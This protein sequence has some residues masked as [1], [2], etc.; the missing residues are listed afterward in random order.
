ME[1]S[2]NRGTPKSSISMAFSIINQPFG[3][4][5]LMETHILPSVE[6]VALWRGTSCPRS[7]L[8]SQGYRPF[9]YFGGNI[10]LY[11]WCNGKHVNIYIYVFLNHIYYCTNLK[12][13][14]K[15]NC[16]FAN[17][18]WIWICFKPEDTPQIAMQWNDGDRPLFVGVPNLKQPIVSWWIP[19]IYHIHS[20]QWSNKET[21]QTP[22]QNHC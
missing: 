19:I 15:E 5:P 3:G 13:N 6:A 20:C 4:S 9:D 16:D 17:E 2:W 7:D 18:E 21:I 14:I 8:S 12:I 1:V 10:Y 11:N 22:S